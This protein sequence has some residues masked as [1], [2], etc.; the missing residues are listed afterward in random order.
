VHSAHFQRRHE[1]TMVDLSSIPL[2]MPL[3]KWVWETADASEEVSPELCLAQVP[4]LSSGCFSALLA[5]ALGV[6]I[7]LG[8]CINKVP[9]IMNITK[10]Q[11]A[12][13][14]SRNSL[15]GEALVYGCGVFYG[16]LHG[17]PFS[18]CEYYSNNTTLTVCCKANKKCIAKISQFT[19]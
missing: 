12:A 11:S 13:G 10:S 2:V 5:K 19:I 1:A 17:Y 7:I 9:L 14:I 18:S 3:A 15:Y 16:L 8:S 4:F 6:A